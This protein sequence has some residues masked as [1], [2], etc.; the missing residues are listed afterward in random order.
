MKCQRKPGIF[1]RPDSDIIQTVA[2][3]AVISKSHVNPEITHVAKG[4]TKNS[5]HA[6]SPRPEKC[7]LKHSTGNRNPATDNVP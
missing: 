3:V 5:L 1:N 2:A 6:V 4:A 7:K